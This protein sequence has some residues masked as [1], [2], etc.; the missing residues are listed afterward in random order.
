MLILRVQEVWIVFTLLY[1]AVCFYI[2][3]AVLRASEW[4]CSDSLDFLPWLLQTQ[5]MFLVS[6]FQI[7]PFYPPHHSES[8]CSV[9][10]TQLALTLNGRCG[11][12]LSWH[13]L[14]LASLDLFLDCHHIDV[15]ALLT[16]LVMSYSFVFLPK[17]SLKLTGSSVNVG[18]IYQL[19]C[20]LLVNWQE[21]FC[22]DVASK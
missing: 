8:S 10:C 1:F 4:T 11:C 2:F 16:C 21:A 19:T 5:S 9:V 22:Y 6:S 7:L 18:V 3:L 13:S 12:Q 17:R 14:V 15:A 20:V